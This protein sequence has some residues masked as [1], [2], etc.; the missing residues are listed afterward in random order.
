MRKRQASGR[1]VWLPWQVTEL[2]T[3]PGPGTDVAIESA[4]VT[5]LKGDLTGIVWALR[6]S[7]ATM[8]NI[9]PQPRVCYDISD[10]PRARTSSS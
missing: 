4:S 10:F 5:L 9:R 7:Q 6:L 3:L 8:G 2:M 1:A